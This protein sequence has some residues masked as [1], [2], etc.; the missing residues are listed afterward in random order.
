MSAS[1]PGQARDRIGGQ[2][3]V[4]CL[5]RELDED[6]EEVLAIVV[7][8]EALQLRIG[9][10]FLNTSRRVRSLDILHLPWAGSGSTRIIVMIP[11]G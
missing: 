11:G 6:W 2:G 10:A 7:D 5:A 8:R 3:D 9:L 1:A 4:H